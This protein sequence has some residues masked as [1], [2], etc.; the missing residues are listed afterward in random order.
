[1]PVFALN[2][3][4]GALEEKGFSCRA[5]TLELDVHPM[6]RPYYERWLS[7]RDGFLRVMTGN[8]DYVGIEDVVRMGPFFN[9]YCLV[10]N[11]FVFELDDN[12][13]NLLDATPYFQL[14]NGKVSSM[15]WSGGVLA[16]ILAKDSE[17]SQEFAK[18]VMKEEVKKL[19]VKAANY[20][21]IIETHVW[22]PAGLASIFGMI[23]RIA[24]DVRKLVK[25]IHLGEKVD[26]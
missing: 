12:A 23:D 3:L 6:R 22:E 19:E 10:E 18:N 17:L 2:S 7:H 16:N 20:A 11:D 1:M 14:H 26:V 24:L 13:H 8:V 5:G 21:C 15:G 4:I 9:V 25:S